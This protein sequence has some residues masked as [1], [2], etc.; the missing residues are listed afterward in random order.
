MLDPVRSLYA[1][2]TIEA[3]RGYYQE[4]GRLSG[5]RSKAVIK[6][7]N[8]LCGE[9]R[10]GARALVDAFGV[11]E[12]VLGDARVVADARRRMRTRLPRAEREAQMLATARALFAARG[13]ARRDDGRGRGGGR[14]HETAALQ[15]LRQQGAALPGLHAAGRGGARGGR[16]LGRRSAPPDA[17][18]A[19][20]AGIHAFFAFLDCRRRGVAAAARRD[21]ARRRRDRGARGRVP[22]ADGGAR[23]RVDPLREPRRRAAG[24]GHLRRRRGAGPLVADAPA[25]C[26]PSAPPSS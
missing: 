24:G 5:A 11:P 18:G 10:P 9:L 14:R 15:L 22:R 4:H 6:A 25:S 8:A 26:P 7:V 12:N 23:D 16:R 17:P 2:S 21:A 3:E 19:L 20:R 13:Y 1:L